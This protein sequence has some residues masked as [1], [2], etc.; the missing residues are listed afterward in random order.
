MNNQSRLIQLGVAAMA[1]GFT[2]APGNVSGI[3]NWGRKYGVDC[4]TCHS[5][6]VPRL[7]ALGH[8]FRKM[9]YRMETEAGKDAKPEAY[10]ELGD[11][12]S[13]RY[14]TGFAAE[15][16]SDLQTAGNGF[17]KFRTRNGFRMPDVT[18]FYAGTLTKNLSLF[19]EIEVADVDETSVQV[20]GE[21]F[22]GD[23]NHFLTIRLGQMHT[24]SRIGWA[25]FDRPT[26]ITTPDALAARKLTTGPV[27]F[28]VGEDQRGLDIAYNF[29][30]NNRIIAGV[31]NGVNRDGA[32]NQ[33]N[34]AG[35]GDSDN[36]KDV[37]LAYEQ[38]LGESGFTLFG[39]YGTWDQA[40]DLAN[41]ILD[42]HKYTEFTF[43]RIGATASWVFNLFDPKKVG[44]SELQAGYMFAKDSYPDQY[45]LALNPSGK[46][47]DG[48]A[49]WAGVEQ[50]LPQNSAVFYRYDQVSRSSEAS[51][52]ARRR[53]TLGAVYTYQQYVRLSLEGF[54]YDQSSDSYGC[55]FQAMFNY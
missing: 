19:T 9:G 34:G 14:R 29:T 36:N 52:G 24:L 22:S 5:P 7:N 31:Y 26:G 21:W 33:F 43:L 37:L 54:A 2:M 46:D 13:I 32:G 8:Q 20:F 45:P 35:Y 18:V 50:R 16:F 25:G 38:M 15:R 3:A 23:P 6:A 47:R 17:N 53:H 49:F 55:L 44:S 40:A 51:G 42:D 10:K 27:P 39:Y 1:I 4:A 41:G 30:P 48:H 28:R 11:W 12:F